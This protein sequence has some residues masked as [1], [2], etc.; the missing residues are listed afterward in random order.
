MGMLANSFRTP[1]PLL[2]PIA[3][4]GNAFKINSLSEQKRFGRRWAVKRRGPM[5]R[6]ITRLANFYFRVAHVPIRFWSNLS[7]WRRWEVDCFRMLNGDRFHAFAIGRRT[8]CASKVPGESL[9]THVERGTLAQPMVEAAAREFRRA[10]MMWSDKLDSLWSH[11]DAGLSN[12]LYDP[13]TNRARLIDFE[14]LHDP[15]LPAPARQ[16]DDLLVFVLDLICYCDDESWLNLSR[17]F[18]RAYG[19]DEVVQELKKLLIVPSGPARIWW[20]IRT[21]GVPT[22]RIERRL[23]EL[24]DSLETHKDRLEKL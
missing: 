15:A 19:R 6:W 1:H 7:A 20:N 8:V 11:G 14:M 24:R 22:D 21:S 3:S 16:A 2:H 12:V 18:L 10:H 23:A 4:V 9:W 17:S 5:S 13:A